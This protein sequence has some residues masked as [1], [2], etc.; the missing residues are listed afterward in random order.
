MLWYVLITTAV[1]GILDDPMWFVAGAGAIGIA[2]LG[3]LI[4]NK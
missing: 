1:A 4:S 3:L 2:F